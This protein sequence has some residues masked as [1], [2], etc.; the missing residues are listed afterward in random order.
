MHSFNGRAFALWQMMCRLTASVITFFSVGSAMS[1]AAIALDRYLA[2]L[3]CLRYSTWP[4]WR[5]V[6]FVLLAIWV[7][8]CDLST[9][10]TGS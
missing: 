9:T 4:R 5:Y 3:H 7:Q 2:I 6:G 8:V 10:E 1:V